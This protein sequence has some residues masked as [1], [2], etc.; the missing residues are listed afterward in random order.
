MALAQVVGEEVSAKKT[1]L[2]DLKQ[3]YRSA[4]LDELKRLNATELNG[5]NEQGPAWP[6]KEKVALL[7]QIRQHLVDEGKGGPPMGGKLGGD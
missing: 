1:S 2:D 3:A 4:L 5:K 6:A 7:D